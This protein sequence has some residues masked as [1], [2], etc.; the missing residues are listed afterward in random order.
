V[1]ISQ[2]TAFFIVTAVGTSNLTQSLSSKPILIL[3]FYQYLGLSCSLLPGFHECKYHMD[4]CLF[5]CV[6]YAAASEE[7]IPVRRLELACVALLG[8]S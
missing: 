5:S 7:F 6:S 3:Y 8:D 4:F 1:F 2:M